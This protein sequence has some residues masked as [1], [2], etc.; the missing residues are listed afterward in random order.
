MNQIA[1][2]PYLN[3]YQSLTKAWP[4]FLPELPESSILE[5]LWVRPLEVQKA[6]NLLIARSGLFF[7]DDIAFGIPGVDAVSILLA[8]EGTGTAI[9][10]E[11]QIRPDFALRITEVPLALKFS[12]ELLQPVRKTPAGPN[13]PA[14]WEVD[15][16][17]AEVVVE[18]AEISLEIDGDGNIGFDLDTGINLPPAMIGDTGVVIEA[19][20]VGLFLDAASPPPGQPAGTKGV[21][22]GSASVY[23]PGEIGEA[24]GPLSLSD[25]FIGNGGF[26]GNVATTF[27]GGLSVELFGMEFRLDAV[28]IGFVQNALTASRIAGSIILPFFYEPVPVE[29]AINLNGSFTVKLGSAANGLYTLTKPGL[30]E[31]ELES[32]G[33]TVEDGL[34]TARMSGAIRPL[35]GG[36]DWPGFKVQELSIDSKGNVHVDGGWIDLRDQYAL[37]FHGFTLEISQ[38]GLG[39]EEDGTRWIG[40]SGGLKLVDGLKA[41]ASVKGLRI[42]WGDDGAPSVSFDGVGV[43]FEVPDVLRFKG[44]VSYRELTV[45]A[46]TVHRFDGAIDL[47]LMCLN[48]TI[49]AKLV[50]GIASGP[51]GSYTF[52]GIYL[53]VDLPAGIPLWST[54]LALYG[55]EGLFAMNMEPDKQPDESWYGMAPGEG[56]FKR[57]QIGVTDINQKWVNRKDSLAVG[58]GITIGTL[59]DNGFTFNG[60]MLL[61]IVFPGP[62]ILIE[63]KANILK[64][65][66]SLGDD[67]IFRALVVL[68][69]RAGDFLVGLDARYKFADAGELIDISA[70]A[71]MYFSFSDPSAW[72]L[73]MGQKEPRERRVRARIFSL[74]TAESYYMLDNDS[75][76]FGSWVGYDA[77]WR[78]GPLRVELEAWMET[79]VKV[80][81]APAHF[82]GDLWAH[83]KLA[84]SV[85]GFGF[86]LSLDAYLSGDVFD[87]FKILAELEA[88]VNLP[89]PLPDFSVDIT[90]EWGDPPVWPLP[91]LPVKEVAIEHLKVGTS[92]ALPRPD[93]LLEPDYLGDDGLR[94]NWD[95]TLHTGYDPT[96]APPADAPVVPLDCRPR[97]TFARNMHD[98][99]L[100]GVMVTPVSPARERIGDPEADEGPVNVKYELTEVAIEAWEGGAWR[101]VAKKSETPDP[102]VPELF[103]SW[104]PIPPMPDGGGQTQ[105]QTKLWLWSKNPFDYTRRTGREWEDWIS[106]R[107]PDMP[108]IE[109]PVQTTRCW[110]FTGVP[111][112]PLLTGEIPFYGLR[113]WQHPET[114]GPL[115]IW[116]EPD[117]PDVRVIGLDGTQDER[118]ICLSNAG[119]VGN[120]PI[121][122]LMV[123]VFPDVPN[124]G[125]TIHCFDPERVTAVAYGA[126]G[127]TQ[128]LIGGIAPEF[129][130]DFN[131][132]D[133]RM[134]IMTWNSRM[135]LW[136]VCLKQGASQAE[137]DEAQVI[138]SHN[139]S[140]TERWKQTGSVL[141]PDTDYRIRITTRID[142][143]GS[144]PLSGTQTVEQTEYA[145]FRTEGAPGL[146][147]LSIP[148][149]APEPEESALRDESG[150]FV[151]VD[152]APAGSARALDSALNDLSLYV[153]QTLPV[154][155]PGKGEARAPAPPGLPRLRRGR[156]VQRR[157]RQ[158]DVSHER[159]GSFALRIRQQQ[160]P[161]PRR[162]RAA[163]R[164]L[165]RL[166]RRH[167]PG[168]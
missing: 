79:N 20:D 9:P 2:D 160:P 161:R 50:I 17:A 89:W 125:A 134:V 136:E 82:H 77:D 36:L 25:A 14:K 162:R 119:E 47:E 106:G 151:L 91:M 71:E 141:K 164:H 94:L 167:R 67:P 37:D 98:K 35:A 97:I 13:A 29:I 93:S 78:F 117:F 120:L 3:A 56:W 142:A 22:I 149:T 150:A 55:L 19:Q 38:F 108:C 16:N 95:T 123:I 99:A 69:F 146:A 121:R 127:A 26:T 86:D 156:A 145:F 133:V 15:P 32:L 137:I 59:P 102:S 80:S 4:S 58:A 90:L 152:G 144:S 147:N 100:V 42:S 64:Q 66:S 101:E 88:K 49:D 39:T 18:F 107:Y 135:C 45:G 122:N 92:W 30:L 12:K 132:P 155:V 41:G 111:L 51:D 129:S 124:N 46:E 62:I 128:V 75:L 126:N 112:G 110:D 73:Y 140:E 31:F 96:G 113:W 70:S 74:F 159:A 43:E 163:D 5:E 1:K 8:A 153:D 6:D 52:L 83:G 105:G 139:V 44:D 130:V 21:A 27:P 24:V 76:A 48:M 28:E 165:Q 23:L 116:G 81:W 104:A 154:T 68:D 131:I 138:A 60:A 7:E 148:L 84:V 57:P 115:F 40:V 157:L 85:F 63:G 168:A 166:G 72:H 103:G 11:V 109:P 53:G 87:P 114:G 143:V 118:G 61:A 54:G 65:R 10:L 158:P 34:F 33:F